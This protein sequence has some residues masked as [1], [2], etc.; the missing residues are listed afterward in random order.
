MSEVTKRLA[1]DVTLTNTNTKL[2]SIKTEIGNTNTALGTANTKLESIKTAIGN[3]N[4]TLGNTNTALGTAN[5][6][7][8][9]IA[10]AIGNLPNSTQEA[11]DNANEAAESA[12]AAIADLGGLI[13]PTYSASNTYK[14]GAYVYKDPYIYRCVTD[15]SVA[16]EWTAA[17]WQVV[18]V[19]NDL[20]SL[21]TDF[22]KVTSKTRNLFG[23]HDGSYAGVTVK[24]L[25]DGGISLVGT[26]AS[27][28]NIMYHLAE[29]F[30]GDYALSVKSTQAFSSGQL[31][32]CVRKNLYTYLN[33]INLN[34][35]EGEL[36]SSTTQENQITTNEITIIEGVTYNTVLY[37]QLEKGNRVT[38]FVPLFTAIDFEARGTSENAIHSEYADKAGIIPMPEM[39]TY[40]TA[41]MSRNV[42]AVVSGSDGVYKIAIPAH[43]N[44][45]G[46]AYA[47]IGFA[48]KEFVANK[49]RV[50]IDLLKSDTTNA[51]NWDA[52]RLSQAYSSWA[53]GTLI[54]TLAQ[55]PGNVSSAKFEIDF[56]QLEIDPDDYTEIY[57]VVDTFRNNPTA[58]ASAVELTAEIKMCSGESVVATDLIGFLPKDY[59][60]KDEVD[61]LIDAGTAT[62]DIAF[63]GDSLTAGA[64]GSGTTYPAVCAALL[65]KR[66]ANCGIGGETEQT[67][68]ARQ[69]GNSLMIPAGSV[70]GQYSFAQMLDG[71][72]KQVLP[73]R[74]GGA[75][76][77]NPVM[78]NGQGCTLSL[79]NET[80]TIS[81]Y[82][83]TLLFDAPALFNGHKII[84]D[85]TVIWVG[86]NGLGSNSVEERISYIRSMLTRAGKKYVIM[87]ISVGNDSNR[88]A[89]DEAM[90]LA[91]GNHFFP[92]RKMLVN[93]GLDVV[94]L[95]PTEQDA[96][97]IAS[98]TVPT[99]L[100]SDGTH[101]NANGYTA[102]GRMLAG[103]IVGLGY[104]AYA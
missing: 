39:N 23:I 14:A 62:T 10:E 32:I 65:G 103:F 17:H 7:L 11:A 22:D 94:G 33:G 60:T 97:D 104:A 2:E 78:I 25:Q 75:N 49:N 50:R 46:Q 91:F 71:S 28:Y 77:V 51:W 37:I 82:N 99:S 6:A 5:E 58:S 24:R 19:G 56:S 47:T 74:Q 43:S 84:G 55:S 85:I 96:A 59:Y 16:E 64:G 54:A 68:A 20:S 92:T 1:T 12:R 4:T 44:Y 30:Y 48:V 63:W 38:E 70:N 8:G 35:K 101:L 41:L 98:G 52:I 69:G 15:I 81:G 53:P 42:K 89:D 57:L 61:E 26:A 79:E 34:G 95:T 21:K 3:T 88:A 31:I 87:G 93:N 66:Y 72:G 40:S 36:V 9:A 73:L 86:T 90:R 18:K 80:Y 76:M 13:A 67:I 100:R 29:A 45:E 102:V 83:G 27:N